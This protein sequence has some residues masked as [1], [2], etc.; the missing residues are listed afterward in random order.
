MTLPV[1]RADLELLETYDY[2]IETP[3]PCPITAFGG[4]R[5]RTVTDLELDGWKS[6]TSGAFARRMFEGDHF[7]VHAPE[8]S[9]VDALS[10]A[11][12]AV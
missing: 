2:R 9:F 8:V 11:L 10:A 6:E 1:L 3:L 7:F 5:D 4:T 12:V